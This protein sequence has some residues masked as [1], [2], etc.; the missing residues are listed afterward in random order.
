MNTPAKG[1]PCASTTIPST[2]PSLTCCPRRDRTQ[3]SERATS[4]EQMGEI[5]LN[6]PCSGEVLFLGS[7]FDSSHCFDAIC[8]LIGEVRQQF[9]NCLSEKRVEQA[10]S[11][12]C[13]RLQHKSPRC[14]LSMRQGQMGRTKN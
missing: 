7:V 1:S 5:R 8:S 14:H 6:M 2:C 4:S 10:R 11:D 13:Q 12:L 3:M 9:S